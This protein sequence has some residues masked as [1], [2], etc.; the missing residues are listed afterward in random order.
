[1]STRG[2][3]TARGVGTGRFF[4]SVWVVVL[5]VLRVISFMDNSPRFIVYL[6]AVSDG[7]SPAPLPCGGRG[8]DERYGCCRVTTKERSL[9]LDGDLA[10]L[11]F[12]GLGQSQ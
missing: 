7:P 4:G 9:G 5:V 2:V 10:R 8:R 12:L 11:G 1:M 3:N 6:S